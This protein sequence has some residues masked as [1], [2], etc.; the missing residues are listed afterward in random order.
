MTRARPAILFCSL[1]TTFLLAGEPAVPPAPEGTK[2]VPFKIVSNRLFIPVRIN[3]AVE[4]EGIIDTGSEVTLMNLARVK[5][6]D[7]K[8]L[9]TQQLEGSFVGGLGA[10]R[11][12]ADALKL[13][14]HEYPQ[15]ALGAFRHGPGQALERVDFILGMDFLGR[16]PFSLELA[17]GR[18][19]LWPFRAKLPDPPEGIERAAL[20]THRSPADS[21]TRPR[22]Y[23]S[24][25]GARTPFLVDTG[26]ES[27]LFA[28]LKAP[29]DLGLDPL[30]ALAGYAQVNDGGQ[31][32]RVELRAATFEKVEFGTM[33]FEKTA[34]RVLDAAQLKS[35]LA[36][37][38][39]AAYYNVVGFA[40]LKD[41]YA[42]HFD[43]PGQRIYFDRKKP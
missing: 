18:M 37:Q 10:Q 40:F 9:G 21:T 11:A 6:A 33:R 19:L 31:A 25:N 24:V 26:A 34:G 4:C 12:V 27:L 32:R 2:A 35:P 41:L 23:G 42:V 14:E 30:G 13:G 3:G 29:A 16:S 7:L 8:V 17:N 5:V 22:V 36:R 1:L 15:V 20:P 28:A 39:L 43:L 38:D